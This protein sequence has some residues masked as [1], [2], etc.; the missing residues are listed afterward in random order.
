MNLPTVPKVAIERMQHHRLARKLGSIQTWTEEQFYTIAAH[1]YQLP[2]LDLSFSDVDAAFFQKHESFFVRNGQLP[3][4]A[5]QDILTVCECEP[6]DERKIQELLQ[7]FELGVKRILITQRNYDMLLGSM[8]RY[9]PEVPRTVEVESNPQ[10]WPNLS[11]DTVEPAEIFHEIVRRADLMKASDIHL[12][13]SEGQLRIRIR[14]HG[15]LLVQRKLSSRE[16]DEVLKSIK[17]D[18]HLLTSSSGTFQ[19]SRIRIQLPHDKTLDLRVEV[20]PTVDGESVVMRLLDFKS[21][22]RA[23]DQLNLP[24]ADYPKL[25]DSISKSSGLIIVTGPTGS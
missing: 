19:S 10:F 2:L 7:Q 9:E 20:S 1:A 15:D 24:A 4:K 11:W 22:D 13:P 12:E 8:S 6:W 18:A 21:I 25:I 16:G 23:I 14:V 5:F 17:L 3:V